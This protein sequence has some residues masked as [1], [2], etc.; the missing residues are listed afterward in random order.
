MSE[1]EVEGAWVTQGG[2]GG[3]RGIKRGAK[4]TSLSL[5]LPPPA[6]GLRCCR[7]SHGVTGGRADRRSPK[8]MKLF[9]ITELG[10]RGDSGKR[11]DRQ[12]LGRGRW[13][14]DVVR[15]RGRVFL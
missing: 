3:S 1:E 8:G 7:L 11:E 2:A 10:R 12:G 13:S 4:N 14:E 5:S 15:Y 6:Q 9:H